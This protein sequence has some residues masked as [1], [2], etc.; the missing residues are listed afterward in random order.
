MQALVRDLRIIEIAE[1]LSPVKDSDLIFNIDGISPQPQVDWVLVGTEFKSD[2][3]QRLES[4]IV[5]KIDEWHPRFLR[6]I[7]AEN[8]AMGITQQGKTLAVQSFFERPIVFGN[9][10]IS[11]AW[12]LATGS[13]TLILMM[14]DY[15]SNNENLLDGLQPFVTMNRLNEWKQEIITLLS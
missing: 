8:I 7:R 15:Y 4:G 2:L 3:V 6:R 13:L 5:A 12:C 14:I 1:N 11:F 10:T 9:H